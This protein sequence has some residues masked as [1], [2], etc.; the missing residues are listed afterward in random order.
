RARS[1]A[2]A[3]RRRRSGRGQQAPPLPPHPLCRTSSGWRKAH[4]PQFPRCPPRERA[5]RAALPTAEV[6]RHCRTD[7]PPGSRRPAPYPFG[8]RV[9]QQAAVE[10]TPAGEEPPPIGLTPYGATTRYW[11][12]LNVF[13]VL[14]VPVELDDRPGLRPRHHDDLVPARQA[15]RDHV[16]RRSYVQIEERWTRQPVLDEDRLNVAA[17]RDLDEDHSRQSRDA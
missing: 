1:R 10:N 8:V 14:R 5:R 17:L 11:D 4:R 2:P 6:G 3:P 12:Q 15:V 13:D 7:R 9:V 16:V